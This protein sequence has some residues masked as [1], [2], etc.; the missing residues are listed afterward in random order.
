M[1]PAHLTEM[2]A[3]I[4]T[5]ESA[6]AVTTTNATAAAAVTATAAAAATLTAAITVNTYVQALN[7]SNTLL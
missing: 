3:A 6:A 2:Y 4:Q 5:G 7:T 1:I